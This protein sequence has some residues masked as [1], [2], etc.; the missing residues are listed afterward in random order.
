MYK[1]NETQEIKKADDI[2]PVLLVEYRK[3]IQDLLDKNDMSDML[4]FAV[5]QQSDRDELEVL[6]RVLLKTFDHIRETMITSNVYSEKDLSRIN[7]LLLSVKMQIEADHFY[8]I[9]LNPVLD[10]FGMGRVNI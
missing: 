3:H 7:F 9:D 4:F 5:I 6:E 8:S 1:E 2:Q 10:G